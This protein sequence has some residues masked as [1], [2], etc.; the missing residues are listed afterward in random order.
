[1]GADELG[2]QA[3]DFSP[4]HARIAH[5]DDGDEFVVA[6]GQQRGPLGEQQNAERRHNRLLR[7][8]VA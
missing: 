5:E 2:L 1:L 8:A 3:D 6:G 4:A 7:G